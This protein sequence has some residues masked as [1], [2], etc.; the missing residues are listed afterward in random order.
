[1]RSDAASGGRLKVAEQKPKGAGKTRLASLIARGIAHP[2]LSVAV[3]ITLAVIG[4]VFFTPSG[5]DGGGRVAEPPISG[6]SES[7]T[8]ELQ[9]SQAPNPLL[10][11]D[12][13]CADFQNTATPVEGTQLLVDSPGRIGGGSGKLKARLLPDGEFVQLLKVSLG[14][15]VEVKALLH[16]SNFT[17]ADGVSVSASI[18]GDSGVCW[19]M[20]VTARVPPD[21]EPR[22]GP[23]LI[24][25]RQGGPAALEY[26]PGS[27][28]LLDE[29]SHVITADLPDGVTQRGV[30][31][32]YAVPGGTAYFL[33]FRVRL[34]A[35]QRP[36]AKPS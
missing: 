3:A 14:S 7:R 30:E 31:L 11:E 35:E 20:M 16:N 6:P 21:G 1:V 36:E 10:S 23:A 32:P 18:V 17:A 19:R 33:S 15:E 12:A 26:V 9:P 25:L 29:R 27:T 5:S 24:L 8:D 13:S 4:W 34:K 22:L 28:R 2:F